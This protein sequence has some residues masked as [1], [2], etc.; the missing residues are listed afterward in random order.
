MGA[1]NS[2]SINMDASLATSPNIDVEPRLDSLVNQSP[3]YHLMSTRSFSITK[4]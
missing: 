4:L 2:G 1:V 3:H